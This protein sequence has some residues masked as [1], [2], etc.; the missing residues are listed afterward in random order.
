MDSQTEARL[1]KLEEALA[2]QEHTVEQLDEEV[3]RGQ[4]EL[5]RLRRE[6]AL[7]E[8]RLLTEPEP[9]EEADNTDSE[10]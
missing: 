1:T 3:R 9:L 4:Q 6:L 7:L 5:E 10:I 8:E 2:F